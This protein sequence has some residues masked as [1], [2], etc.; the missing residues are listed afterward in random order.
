MLL[1]RHRW[2]TRIFPVTKIW[3]LVKIQFSSFTCEDITVVMTTLVSANRKLPSQHRAFTFITHNIILKT[4]MAFSDQ[5]PNFEIKIFD[6]E[7]NERID[8]RFVPMTDSK[9]DNLIETEENA[10]AK[11]KTLYNI[12]FVKQFLTEHGERKSIEE[13]PAVKL[14]NY[15]SKFK[16]AARTK[17]GEEY[18]SSSLGGILS[19]VERHLRRAGYYQRQRFSKDTRYP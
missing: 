1:Y 18:E 11:R 2:N 10:T 15:V 5:L 4:K 9:V 14:N 13:I 6:D 8:G 12:N 16:V 3:Y 7:Q 17:K 19:S